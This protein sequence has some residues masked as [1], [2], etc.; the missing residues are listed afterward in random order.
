[1]T[2]RTDEDRI[3]K[4]ILALGEGRSSRMEK[5]ALSGIS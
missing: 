5:H 3:L 2:L 4:R 1:V